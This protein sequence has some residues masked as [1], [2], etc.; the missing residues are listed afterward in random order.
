MRLKV[1]YDHVFGKIFQRLPVW[2]E[3]REPLNVSACTHIFTKTF[4]LKTS[5]RRPD[6]CKEIAI[7]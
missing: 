4:F 3:A 5:G 7:R 1:R 6:S 2:Q